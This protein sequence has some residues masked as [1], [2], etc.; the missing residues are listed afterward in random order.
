M[1]QSRELQTMDLKIV[2]PVVGAITIIQG[3]TRRLSSATAYGTVQNMGG[4]I[5]GLMDQPEATAS[6]ARSRALTSQAHLR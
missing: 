3:T 2:R 1:M 4:W 6:L 5:V